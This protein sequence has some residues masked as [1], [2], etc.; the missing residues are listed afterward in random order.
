MNR[1]TSIPQRT[2]ENKATVSTVKY[3]FIPESEQDFYLITSMGD[4][5]DILASQFYGDSKYW[6]AIASSNPTARRD[7][8]LLEPGLQ[9]RIPPIVAILSQFEIVN[10]L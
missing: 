3:P 1:Y 9:L 8:L 5:F 10:N 6:W 7:T 2:I 4:R